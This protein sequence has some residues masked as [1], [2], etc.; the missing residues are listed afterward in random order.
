MATFVRL[1]VQRLGP[2]YS[3]C[4]EG[5]DAPGSLAAGDGGLAGKILSRKANRVAPAPQA[6][7]S[8]TSRA[9]GT[10]FLS[11]LRCTPSSGAPVT[12]GGRGLL[13][14]LAEMTNL[15]SANAGAWGTT[16][17]R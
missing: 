16:I 17:F 15:G 8:Q 14:S 7:T 1:S 13:A 3:G 6:S 4:G 10:V 5:S 11:G 2:V 12:E 9:T